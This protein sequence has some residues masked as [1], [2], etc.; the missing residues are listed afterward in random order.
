MFLGGGFLGRLLEDSDQACWNFSCRVALCFA[1]RVD[2]WSNGWWVQQ[3][4]RFHSVDGNVFQ[5]SMSMYEKRLS[6]T[7]F[8]FE[9]PLVRWLETFSGCINSDKDVETLELVLA[10]ENLG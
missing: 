9:R 7:F 5:F 4:S 6:G 10:Y 8:D 2:H 1:D 3:V